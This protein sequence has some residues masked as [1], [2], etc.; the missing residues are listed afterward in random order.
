M[1]KLQNL[2]R[3][4]A[5]FF[6]LLTGMTARAEFTGLTYEVVATTDLGTTYR[7]YANFDE[8]TDNLQ[9]VYGEF[10]NALAIT[11][12]AGFYQD[13]GGLTP[14]GINPFF[15]SVYPDLVYDSWITIGQEDSTSP[16]TVQVAGS[17]AGWVA[18]QLS[19]EGGGNFV[20]NDAVGGSLYTTPSLEI[21]YPD[22][23]GRILVAQLTTTGDWN[24]TCNLQWRDEALTVNNEVGLSIG[25][26]VTD[27]NGLS[28]ELVG[29]NT[30]SEGFDTYRVYANFIDPGAQLVAVYGMQDT[31]LSIVT[32]GTFYQDPV[33]GPTST[34]SNPALFPGFP[35]LEYDSWVTIGSD[36]N[37]GTVEAIGLDFEPFEAGGNLIVDD[38]VGGT[39]T[40]CLVLSPP[41]CRGRVLIGQ[42]TTDGIVDMIVN[43]QY[44]AADGTNKQVVNQSLTFQL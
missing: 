1:L 19:F 38:V 20:V 10:P 8:S 32:S 24:M 30:T 25:Y 40:F 22:A 13:D 34:T 11:S 14:S 27:Y 44:R 5:A 26:E 18:A 35:S 23:Q 3:C 28:F 42:F 37:F 12:S 31:V 7:V 21:G 29:E 36:D 41:R 4:A 16:S 15:Y 33:G 6:V 17:G 9:A 39:G 2:R 43:M